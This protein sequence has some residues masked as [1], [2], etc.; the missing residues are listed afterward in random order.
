MFVHRARIKQ[1]M[2]LLGDFQLSPISQG[3]SVHESFA[4]SRPISILSNS[5]YLNQKE[6]HR[7]LLPSLAKQI[8]SNRHESSKSGSGHSLSLQSQLGKLPVPSLKDTLPTFLR[9]V[10][11]LLNNEEYDDTFG[12]VKDFAKEG[13]I[14]HKLQTLLEERARKTENWFSDWWLDMA[15][16]GYRDPVIVWSSPGIVWPTQEFEDK[17]DMIKFAAKAIAGALDYKIAVDNKTIPVEMQGGKP[18]DMQQYFKVFGTTR[19][20]ALPLDKQSFNPESK[21]IIVIYKN[22]FFKVEVYGETG[23]QL[24]AE[25][26]QSSLEDIVK[27]VTD[28]GPEIGILTS[29]NR[30]DWSKDFAL[31][32]NNKK[33][34]ASLKEI[35]TALFNM[36]LDP[37]F[38]EYQAH[39]DLSRS[40][41]ISLHG[42]GSNHAGANRWHDKTLQISVAESGECGMTYEHSPAEGPPL[43]ILTDH[44]L[45]YI[46]GTIKNGSNLPAI[47]YSPVQKLEFVL[48]DALDLSISK[49]KENLDNLVNEV[50]MHVLHFKHFG[51]NEIKSLGFSPDSFIQIAIQ[52]AFYRLQKEP[53][54][55]YESGGTR[56]FIHG[57]TEVIRSCSI[58]SVDFAKAVVSSTGTSNDKFVLMKRA[59]QGHNSYARLAVAGLGVD[60]H[61]QG[62]KMISLENGIDPHDL[63][64]DEG[65]IKS[66]RM[67]ISTSQV[68]GSTGSFLCFGPLVSDGYGCCYNPRSNDIFLPCSAL[69]SCP[70]TSATAFRDSVE[71][72]LID[73]RLLALENSQQSKL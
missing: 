43:M 41:L 62:M 52:L 24:S 23:E 7:P 27:M 10:R 21:H 18:L 5:F 28:T 71:Q 14:G 64:S 58:E 45:G 36:N 37:N 48:N 65:Y 8:T 53:G 47:K 3:Y 40:A 60:R 4:N 61:L 73:M 39:D 46:S 30:D 68:A 57:R 22:Y 38:E 50:D 35:E 6:D 12:K 63:F 44:I 19:M 17:N 25:Q 32:A 51:K 69:N 49:A 34:K 2:K 20:P 16:L 1:S 72:S 56:Q 11:P 66:S 55:H 42:G 54:A 67:R 9:T 13:G 59:I 33:N 26:I 15:Y 70:E 31:L 29:N